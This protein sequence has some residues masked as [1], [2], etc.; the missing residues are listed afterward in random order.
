MTINA[1]QLYTQKFSSNVALLAQ[2]KLSRL[3]STVTTDSYTGEQVSPIN[4]AG[5][6]EMK[7]VNTR[8]QQKQRSDLSVDRRWLSPEDWDLQQLV[9]TFDKMKMAVELQSAEVAAAVAARNRRKDY[10]I[11]AAFFADARTGKNGGST[12]PFPT[13]TDT[14][15]VSVSYGATT[16][17]I[18]VAKLKK[19]L[20]LFAA[21]DVDIDEEEIFCGLSPKGNT[22]LLNDI[23]IIDGNFSGAVRDAKGRLLAWNGISFKHG[24][25]YETGTDD[26]SGTSRAIPMWCKSGMHL[27]TWTNDVTRVREAQEYKGNP[28]ELYCYQSLNATRI[29]E[30]KVLKIWCREA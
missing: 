27:G 25:N 10:S 17:N 4:Q 12:T 16:S 7:P 14:N 26:A 23:E 5:K 28:W 9:D 3:E 29:E 24:N 30:A 6:L 20:E 18:S 2:Q 19:G 11:I 8:F 1:P 13:S 15:V 22:A 21:N